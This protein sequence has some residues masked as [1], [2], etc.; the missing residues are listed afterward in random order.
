MSPFSFALRA[1]P[2]SRPALGLLLLALLASGCASRRARVPPAPIPDSAGETRRVEES[3]ERTAVIPATPVEIPPRRVT[4]VSTSWPLAAASPQAQPI[5]ALARGG[6]GGTARRELVY[7]LAVPFPAGAAVLTAPARSILDQLAARLNLGDSIFYLE[8]QGHADASGTDVR[9][10]A[11]ALQR[12]QV[13]RDYL[14]VASGLPAE[15]IALVSLGAG[16]PV[17]DNSTPAGRAA[18]RR[19]VVLALR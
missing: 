4:S 10:M 7:A 3:V 19:V 9:N 5:S 15:R 2:N 17:A 18:N 11:I 12:A 1:G 13:V 14:L 16:Q 6:A 8:I